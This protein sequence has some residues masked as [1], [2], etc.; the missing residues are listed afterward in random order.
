VWDVFIT[1]GMA[2][3]QD[4]EILKALTAPRPPLSDPG[5]Q[6]VREMS[7]A[8]GYFALDK[9]DDGL[10]IL[11]SVLAIDPAG[12]GEQAAREIRSD[13][14]QAVHKMVEIGCLLER[15]ALVDEGVSA[16]FKML[17]ESAEGPGRGEY[18]NS[19]DWATTLNELIASGRYRQAQELTIELLRMVVRP[20]R[21]SAIATAGTPAGR[22][23]SR[24]LPA[25]T[26][27]PA[28]MPTF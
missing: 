22:G 28:A 26:V 1:A 11:R 23:C 2:A 13:R 27:R 21:P 4:D 6:A 7:I 10:A 20:P 18:V 9:I 14:Q 24:S 3:G 5:R 19:G 16:I 17:R 8:N 15:Q 25:F 12:T